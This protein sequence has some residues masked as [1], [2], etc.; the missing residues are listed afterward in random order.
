MNYE[1]SWT[2][3]GEG[4]LFEKTTAV[5][6]MDLSSSHFKSLMTELPKIVK[7]LGKGAKVKQDGPSSIYVGPIDNG[8]MAGQEISKVLK[9]F[10]IRHPADVDMRVG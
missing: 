4:L 9:K 5:F 7:K 2:T 3:P 10:K 6:L 1:N 8:L